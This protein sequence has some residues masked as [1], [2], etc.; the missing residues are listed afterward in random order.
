MSEPSDQPIHLW[1]YALPNAERPAGGYAV[2]GVYI[3][4]FTKRV[5]DVTCLAC[6]GI[7]AKKKES[8]A[9]ANPRKA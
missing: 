6:L 8:S 5:E 1:V 3:G 2:C 4:K 7:L 9:E